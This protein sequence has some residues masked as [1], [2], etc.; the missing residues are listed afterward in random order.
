[1]ETWNRLLFRIIFLI[2]LLAVC[3]VM[4]CVRCIFKIGSSNIKMLTH[5][6]RHERDGAALDPEILM[7]SKNVAR[8]TSSFQGQVGDI[9]QT[10]GDI[11]SR[12][13]EK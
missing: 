5:Q 4:M 12:I 9:L 8:G 10:F 2:A 1:M 3:N 6:L 11:A 7:S 13:D